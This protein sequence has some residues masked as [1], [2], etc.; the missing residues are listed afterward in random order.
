[1]LQPWDPL[2]YKVAHFRQARKYTFPGS[3]AG[4][5]PIWEFRWGATTGICYVTRIIVK[6]VQT[7]AT[8]SASFEFPFNIQVA[9]SFTA[10]DPTNTTSILRSGNNQKLNTA[11][12]ASKLSEFREKDSSANA[13]T[14]GTLTQDSDP[15]AI[16]S[17]FTVVPAAG[18][19]TF[20]GGPDSV[21][22]FTY[23]WDGDQCLRLNANEGFVVNYTGGA[24]PVT[25]GLNVYLEVCWVEATKP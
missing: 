11:F 24:G 14:G 5:T 6:A 10:A 17:Y 4:N 8:P 7:N 22:D 20:D 16:G 12:L 18:T 3:I 19:P 25:P 21:C 15:I 13:A 23:S 9:R 2:G 1:M